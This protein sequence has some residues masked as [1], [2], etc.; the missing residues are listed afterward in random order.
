MVPRTIIN[1]S[2]AP[3]RTGIQ[4]KDNLGYELDAQTL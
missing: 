1:G 3:P 4:L 2:P